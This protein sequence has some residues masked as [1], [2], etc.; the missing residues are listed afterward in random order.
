MTSVNLGT[1][2]SF[3]VLAGTSVTNT[4]TSVINGNLG[5]SPG[6]S[7]TGF[8]PGT[9]FGHQYVAD[10][11]ASQ[12]QTYLTT[13][14]NQAAGETPAT[15]ESADLAGLTLFAGVYAVPAAATNLSGTL[16][17]D[18]QNDPSSVFIFKMSST[19]IT[20]S[21]SSVVLEN[22][23]QACNVFWQVGSSATLGTSTTFVGTI[24]ALTSITADTGATVNGRLLALN[25]DVTLYDNTVTVPFCITK[26]ASTTTLQTGNTFSYTL[27]VTNNASFA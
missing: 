2:S 1:A 5:L 26:T 27:Y 3:A 19:L 10:T 25:G 6:T 13:A 23:A 16:I 22:G 17:L 8:P 12:A 14:Y 7:V 4:G 15:S 18:G 9:V 24:L 11:T 20:A 21:G